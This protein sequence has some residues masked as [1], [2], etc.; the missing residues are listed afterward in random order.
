MS[1]S[2]RSSTMPS[3]RQVAVTAPYMHDGSLPTLAAVI[4]HYDSGGYAHPNKSPLV[5]PLGL[6]AGEKADLLA[7][8]HALTDTGFLT[9]PDFRAPE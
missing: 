6:S 8:L 3:L 7:F 2:P 9:N 1:P 5:R 4:D